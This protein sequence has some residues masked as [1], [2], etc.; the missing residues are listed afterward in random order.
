MPIRDQFPVLVIGT[1]PSGLVSLKT[2]LQVGVKSVAVD[3]NSAIGG[4]WDIQSPFSSIYEST[5]LISSKSMTQFVDFPM[6]EH[7]PEYPGHRDVLAYLHFYA[8]RFELDPHIRTQTSV[9]S[10]K[11]C[12]S[13]WEGELASGVNGSTS[14][15]M[16]SAIVIAN[17]HHAEPLI[18][19]FPGNFDGELIHAHDYKQARQ[20][21]GKRVLVVG[22]GNSGCDIAVEA[23][24][25]GKS[26]AISM[27]RGYHFFPKFIRGR[28]ADLVADRLRRWPIPRW[29]Q[30]KISRLVVDW[31]IGRPH[32]YGLPEPDH[33]LFQSHPII[34]S[35]L[36]YYAGHGKLAVFPDVHRL[37]G[38]EVEF[39][40]GRRQAFDL[41]VLATG[42][43]VTFP[44]IESDLL[45]T[46][47]GLP[48][49]YLHAFHPHDDTLFVAG[50]IQPNSGQ[51]PLT[52]LQAQIIARFLKAS[53]DGAK[54][55]DWFRKL[56]Q[57]DA[58]GIPS[59]D[60]FLA[61]PRH[62]LEVDY[63]EYRQ[64]LTNIVRK[65]DRM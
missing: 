47:N 27:R 8:E 38:N 56:R 34:N 3:R 7:Y 48:K 61:T 25:H 52:D 30:K 41:I 43:H 15:E 53:R 35:Q 36:P 39:T 60:H 40:D 50:M 49:L 4:N 63:Y 16:F 65:F 31:T 29:W 9:V 57:Q 54:E 44:F 1:G 59:R 22:A 2:L 26:A 14:R 51:W 45:N 21:E 19:Q 18:P 42:Y 11:K 55:A 33:E 64:I 62:R 24:I 58:A 37:E 6:P 46:Q 32:R 10:L 5:H 12:E 23:A 17:G 13:G 28:P 20:L